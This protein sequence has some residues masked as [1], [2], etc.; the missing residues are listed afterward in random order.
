MDPASLAT[1]LGAQITSRTLAPS[2][3][4][5]EDNRAP[6]TEE[7]MAEFDR[8]FPTGGPVPGEPAPA[9]ALIN[10][11]INDSGSTP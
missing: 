5:A 9:D 7:Q 4:R 3:A 1:M 2:E 11:Q 6:F 10:A 8:L